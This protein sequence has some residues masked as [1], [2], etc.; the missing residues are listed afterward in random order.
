MKVAEKGSDRTAEAHVRIEGKLNPLEEYG[1]HVD[2]RDNAICCYIP[3][4]ESD[5]L[6]IAS[7]FSGTVSKLLHSC[8]FLTDKPYPR[9]WSLRMMPLLTECAARPTHVRPK[10]CNSRKT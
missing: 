4:H 6:K 2:P 5:T 3:V 8:A 1:E 7:R 9:L 10:R